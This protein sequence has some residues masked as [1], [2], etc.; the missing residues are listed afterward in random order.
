MTEKSPQDA[1]RDMVSAFFAARDSLI[2]QRDEAAQKVL[3][4]TDALHTIEEAL[5]NLS[6]GASPVSSLGAPRPSFVPSGEVKEDPTPD[7]QVMDAELQE[8]AEEVTELQEEPEEE[9]PQEEVISE[10]EAPEEEAAEEPA[11]EE[12]P[13]RPRRSRKPTPE[14]DEAPEVAPSVEETIEEEEEVL[15]EEE[16][17]A[18]AAPSFPPLDAPEE[19]PEDIDD[20]PF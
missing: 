5:G 16:P 1:A 9:A 2:V 6:S 13:K 19:E 12:K 8:L 11:P 10:E 14:E 3:E 7:P 17:E 15:Q 18:P 4:W 20:L